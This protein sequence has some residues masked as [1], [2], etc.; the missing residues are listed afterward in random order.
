MPK[1]KLERVFDV[2]ITIDKLSFK[3]TN[4]AI[5]H[6]NHWLEKDLLINTISIKMIEPASKYKYIV[7]RPT[8]IETHFEL[9]DIK[10]DS[11][12]SKIGNNHRAEDEKKASV[13]NKGGTKPI[14]YSTDIKK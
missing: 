3:N 1:Y 12:T 14:S 13:F 10:H 7:G 2:G 5:K 6:A 11:N 8:I 9:K 4:M